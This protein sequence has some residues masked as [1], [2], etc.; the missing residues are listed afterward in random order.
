M[1]NIDETTVRTI[2]HSKKSLLFNDGTPW[3]K[4]ANREGFDVTMGSYDGAET[5]ELVGI[6]LLHRMRPIVTNCSGGL[7][8][9]DGLI[10]VNNATG[11]KAD[12][13][14]KDITELFKSE[15]LKITV[16]TN[17]STTNFLDITLDLDNNRFCPYTKP[18]NTPRYI[19]VSSNHPQTIIRQL[20]KMINKRISDLS[21]TEKEFTNAK[22]FYEDALKKSGHN[23]ELTYE[24]LVDDKKADTKTPRERKRKILWFNPPFSRSVLTN[25]GKRFFALLSKH[26]GKDSRYHKLFNRNSVKL[27]YSCTPNIGMIIKNHNARLQS[28]GNGN[29]KACSCRN[30]SQCPLDGNCMQTSLVYEA[31]VITETE[32]F[33]YIGLCEGDLKT[34]FN[35]HK[36]TF[37]NRKYCNSTE[38]SKRIWA[39][40]DT[41]IEYAVKWKILQT[42]PARR[43]GSS[44]CSLC[45]S[46]KYHIITAKKAN[47]NKRNELMSKCRHINKH[48][49][50][51]TRK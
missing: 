48:L 12:R 49:L 26:F 13:I 39:L 50:T 14:R 31:E 18:N 6:Y 1:T 40:K 3:T 32:K 44:R 45:L 23:A 7:Y 4:I 20:P 35:T 10:V 17:T 38:L 21:S 43:C 51:N 30:R 33:R 5:C 29:R 19:H 2:K 37:R 25:I 36:S 47:L 46:E 27:S 22:K 8:R 9:D 41:N 42:T 34:R 28:K 24:K 15:G 16:E 11:P